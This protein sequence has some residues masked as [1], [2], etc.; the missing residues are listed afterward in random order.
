[1]E[2][3]LRLPAVEG[4][5]SYYLIRGCKHR[6]R[7]GTNS[8]SV[9]REA[10]C[11]P[12]E[13]KRQQTAHGQLLYDILPWTHLG[14]PRA[15]EPHAASCLCRWQ[16]LGGQPQQNRGME[17]V[18]S[19]RIGRRE[20]NTSVIELGVKKMKKKFQWLNWERKRWTDC[21]RGWVRTEQLEPGDK[22]V[23]S[24]VVGAKRFPSPL[25]RDVIPPRKRQRQEPSRPMSPRFTVILYIP[26]ALLSL[27]DHCEWP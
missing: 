5:G 4:C 3:L 21:W 19:S 8:R 6:F 24:F 22:T 15:R 7:W 25:W 9:S 17:S 27:Q 11:H 12:K 20:K 10:H 2:A 23:G 1:M 18:M 14:G 16:L 26:A 13:M